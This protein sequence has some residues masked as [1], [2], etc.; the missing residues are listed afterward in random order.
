LLHYVTFD[1]FV[2]TVFR[3]LPE[4]Y[5]KGYYI[6]IRQSSNKQSIK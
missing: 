2:K 4:R 5:G 3:K 6:C 1:T